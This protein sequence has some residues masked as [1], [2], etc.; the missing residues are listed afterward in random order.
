M[1][2]IVIVVIIVHYFVMAKAALMIYKNIET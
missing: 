1:L 2:T